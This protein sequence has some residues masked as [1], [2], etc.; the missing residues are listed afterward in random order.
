MLTR[1]HTSSQAKYLTRDKSLS[2]D[3]AVKCRLYLRNLSITAFARTL[4]PRRHRNTV[5]QA[6]H[7]PDYFPRVVA[8]INQALEISS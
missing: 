6:I 2:Y 5:S 3:Q 8:Q 4:R 7:H 1:M